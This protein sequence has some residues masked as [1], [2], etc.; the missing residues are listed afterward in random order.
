MSKSG[1]YII[2]IERGTIRIKGHYVTHSV[3]SCLWTLLNPNSAQ[4]HKHPTEKNLPRAHVYPSGLNLIHLGV[5]RSC[6][7]ACLRRISDDSENF[8]N[9]AFVSRRPLRI[10]SSY[11]AFPMFSQNKN[12]K[13]KF[14][15]L[16][17]ISLRTKTYSWF[18]NTLWNHLC[19][20]WRIFISLVLNDKI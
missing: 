18:W 2:Y 20:A 5:R 19:E 16:A 4:R 11:S 8:R 1:Y 13:E 15:T 7:L 12:H 17:N 3:R 9:D 14:K 10:L 6:D